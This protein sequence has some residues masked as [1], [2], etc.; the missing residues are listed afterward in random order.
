MFAGKDFVA[1]TAKLKK[2]TVATPI[3]QLAKYLT[4]YGRADGANVP[5]M[6]RLWQQLGQWGWGGMTDEY[7]MTPE[8]ALMT[9]RIRSQ[10]SGVP[11]TEDYLHVDWAEYGKRQ[12][13]WINILLTDINTLQ[14]SDHEDYNGIAMTSCRFKHEIEPLKANGFSHYL[15]MCSEKTRTAR[16]AAAGYVPK[17]AEAN[18]VSEQLAVEL[19]TTMEP[20]HI[21]W[22]DTEPKPCADMLTVPEFMALTL[23][24]GVAV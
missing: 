2:L 9:E 21:I 6:R 23:G 17:S 20:Y 8:R 11:M 10:N 22:N 5:G 16:M 7:P 12:D 4:G 19:E 1:D 18:D 3:Y 14:F 24:I 13:F 15:V